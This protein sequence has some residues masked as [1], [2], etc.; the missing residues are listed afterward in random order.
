MAA[1]LFPFQYGNKGGL[2]PGFEGLEKVNF[3]IKLF[4]F[5]SKLRLW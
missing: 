5:V 1:Q 2:I 4:F 3:G